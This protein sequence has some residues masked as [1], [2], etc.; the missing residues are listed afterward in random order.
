MRRG[1]PNYY[2]VRP[3]FKFP[4]H[5]GILDYNGTKCVIPVITY[6]TPSLILILDKKH[7]RSRFVGDGSYSA[8][9]D[10]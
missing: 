2:F 7:R 10:T 5:Q 4:V 6:I 3:Q 9:T 8:Y 1:N